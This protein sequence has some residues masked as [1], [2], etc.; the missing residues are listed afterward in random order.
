MPLRVVA[1]G[2]CMLELAR[3]GELWRLGAAGDAFNTALYLRRLGASVR[4]LTA[5]GVDP[6][7]QEMLDCWSG[8]GLDTSL[9]LRDQL[10]LPGLYAIRTDTAGE[11]S[12]YYWRERSA[13]RRL[14]QHDGADAALQAAADCDLLY[15]TGITLSLYTEAERVRLMAL[16]AEVRSRGGR[17]AFDPNY[18]PR[19]WSSRLEAITAF[20][21]MAPLADFV[22]TTDTDDEAL[23][24]LGSMEASAAHWHAI[25][26][27][28][29][30]V[31]QGAR[32]AGG[33][34]SGALVHMP[35]PAVV[36]VL[37]TTG[38]GDSFNAA[39]LHARLLGHGISAALVAGH[40]LAGQVVQVHGAIMPLQRPAGRARE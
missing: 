5:L 34:R 31:K 21:A 17:V 11:R 23:W 7:S 32:G 38:A 13:A 8:E 40:R 1:A 20:T 19:G 27:I 2:E 35:I 37:D 16:A 28:E 26:A 6:F 4:F 14:F 30:I 18:R 22:L 12:F 24:G 25:G 10:A 39:Y 29:V 33:G 36:P 15:F 9:V 3:E